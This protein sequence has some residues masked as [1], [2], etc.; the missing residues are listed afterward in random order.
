MYFLNIPDKTSELSDIDLSKSNKMCNALVF[1]LDYLEMLMPS[2][3]VAILVRQ[4]ASLLCSVVGVGVLLLG[5]MR[6]KSG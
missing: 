5:E 2:D 3:R 1:Y 4:I 6:L